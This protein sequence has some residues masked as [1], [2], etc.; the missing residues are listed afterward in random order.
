[1]DVTITTTG[2]ADDLR[3]L[4]AWLVQENELRGRVSL[5]AAPPREGTLGSVVEVLLAAVGSGGAI[6]VLIGGI[7][8]WLRHRGQD[9]TLEITRPD[10]ASIKLDAKRMRDVN[11]EELQSL[12]ASYSGFLEGRT[13]P[14]EK[15]A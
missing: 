13:E 15:D 5:P 1:V 10:G 11:V 14:V 3:S 12:A 9:V 2:D 8:S 6:T 4:R 7:V